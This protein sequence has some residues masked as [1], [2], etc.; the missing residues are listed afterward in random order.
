MAWEVSADLVFGSSVPVEL[1][2]IHVR[3]GGALSCSFVCLLRMKN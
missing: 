2:L 3:A 1:T